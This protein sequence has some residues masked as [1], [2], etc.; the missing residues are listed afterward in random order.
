[1][2]KNPAFKS[3]FVI[4]HVVVVF[5]AS[6]WLACGAGVAHGGNVVVT[7]A[8]DSGPGSLRQAVASAS[9]G[10]TITFAFTGTVVLTSGYIE[11]TKNLNIQGP[12]NPQSLV[13]ERSFAGGTPEFR[14]F[15]VDDGA[16]VHF[17]NLSFRNG[18]AAGAAIS[19][20]GS[21]VT[22]TNCIFRENVSPDNCG[23]AIWNFGSKLTVIGCSFLQNSALRYL[24][25]NPTPDGGGGICSSEATSSGEGTVIVQNSTFTNNFSQTGGGAIGIY[26]AFLGEGV[27][28]VLTVDNCTFTDN[29]TDGSGGAISMTDQGSLVV[30]FSTFS[31]NQADDL[32]GAISSFGDVTTLENSTFEENTAGTGGAFFS[33]SP[34]GRVLRSLFKNNTAPR[35]GA[36]Y[37]QETLGFGNCTFSGNHTSGAPGEGGAIRNAGTL[38]LTACTFSANSATTGGGVY[39]GFTSGSQV[40]NIAN[41]IFKNSTIVRQSGTVTSFGFNLANDNGGGFLNHSTDRI[42]TDPKLDSLGLQDNGGWTDTIALVGGSPAIDQGHA[43][44]FTTDQRGTGFPRTINNPGIPNPGSGDGTD[45]GAYEAPIDAIQDSGSP[46]VVNTNGDHDDGVCGVADCSLRDAIVRSNAVTGMNIIT[47]APTVTGTITLQTGTGTPLIINDATKI[48]GPG[49]RVLRIS[50]NNNERVLHFAAGQSELTGLTIHG[51]KAQPPR[52]AASGFGGGILNQAQLMVKDCAF[53][54]NQA[55]GSAGLFPGQ[56]GGSGNGGAI[57]NEGFLT[58]DRCAFKENVALGAAGAAHTGSLATGGAG[59]NGRGGAVY[60]SPTS[61]ALIYNCTFANNTAQGG[62]GGNGYSGGAGGAGRGAAIYNERDLSVYASTISNN[63]SGGG[64]GGTGN[65]GGNGVSGIGIGGIAAAGSFTTLVQNSIVAANFG[66]NGGGPDAQ[67]TFVSDGYN[68]IGI[69]D[70]SSGFNE[71]GDQVGTTAAPINAMLGP[72][73]N[74]GGPTDTLALLTGSPAL[75]QGISG[76]GFLTDQ[77]GQAR[78]NDNPFIPNAPGGN[79]SDIGAFEFAGIFAVTTV[80]DGDDGT[81]NASH[82]TL[83]EAI[84][85]ANAQ[86]GEDVI[87]FL[88]G[89]NGIIQLASALPI[90]NTNMMLQGPGSSVI[91]VRRNTGGNYRIFTI[92]NGTATGPVVTIAGLTIANGRAAAGAFPVNSGG[93]ILNDRGTLTLSACSLNG[94]MGDPGESL[95]GGILNHEGTLVVENSTLTGNNASY[96][97]GICNYED[98]ATSGGVVIVRATTFTANTSAYGGA[99]YTQTLFSGSSVDSSLT[100]CT[101]SGNSATAAGGAVYN[102]AA[103]AG[104]AYTRLTDCTLSGNSAPDG[105]GIYNYAAGANGTVFLRNNILKTGAS[106]VNVVNNAG[107]VQSSG[108]N[109]TND[110]SGFASSSG[111]LRNTEPMLGPLAN[112]GGLTQTHALLSGSPAINAGTSSFAPTLD[113][114]G[115]SYAGANDIGAYEFNGIPPGVQLLGAASRKVHGG[116][117]TFDIALPLTGSPGIECRAGGVYQLIFSFANTLISVG[118]ASVTSGT[119][120]VSSHMIGTDAHNY[121]VNLTGVTNV[122]VITVSLTNVTDSA[123]RSSSS[124]PISM[125]VLV[126][127]T[128]ADRFV[129]S[130]DIG[131]TKS[132]SGQAV[133]SSNFRQDATVEGSL[134]SA[135]ISLVKSKSGT[136]LP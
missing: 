134:N 49:A 79:G 65:G 74:N 33:S 94:N 22:V 9:S 19:S 39:S 109:L 106:G 21:E 44:G 55:R 99:I 11:I 35:G 12:G 87:T 126:G 5:I 60:N 110:N 80:A 63:T 10:D 102:T 132:K 75:D 70:Q 133:D 81:C 136:S 61:T 46:Y 71:T 104:N 47:F 13:V 129:N 56:A 50:G 78:P 83:R 32:G 20:R 1:M 88:P 30:N 72:V 48:N 28:P 131:Q 58:L 23:G 36:V 124:I 128:T 121:I 100:N 45:I 8:A 34:D 103:T 111:D 84:N 66:G 91:T 38:T 89:V 127:D 97:A 90:L 7:T 98:T 62:S 17:S 114:R 25:S 31:G 82:C 29:T 95:G 27:P 2:K 37:L 86:G 112:N 67:G 122:Q 64:L 54:A 108:N 118:G 135:D 42:N 105:G 130:A 59:G 73:Q 85:A 115:Y 4:R 6:L 57:G 40:A 15:F 93:G 92:S 113:Q 53:I 26:G 101:L 41:T 76:T 119:G 3:G 117:G 14:L 43:F 68:L 120:S 116:A 16:V 107:T 77:R 69:G 52:E 123:G 125:A 96:G 24:N 51:G 18:R